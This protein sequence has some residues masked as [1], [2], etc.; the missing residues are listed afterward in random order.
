MTTTYNRSLSADFG[1]VLFLNVFDQE[2]R[3]SSITAVLERVDLLDDNVDIVFQSALS[4]PEIIILDNLIAVHPSGNIEV[5]TTE[6]M[7]VAGLG[8]SG[9]G[10]INGNINIDININELSELVTPNLNAD[11]IVVFDEDSSEHRKVLLANAFPAAVAAFD[12]YDNAGGQTFDGTAITVN[13]D[14]V[15]TN[16]GGF[17]LSSSEVTVTTAGTYLVIFRVSTDINTGGARSCSRAL[18]ELNTGGGFTEVDGS[19]GYMYNRTSGNA[20]YVSCDC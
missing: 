17:S 5:S 15:R 1:G 18:L 19:S 20:D 4:A 2:I 14:T 6:S 11:F 13:L 12:A 9:G 10:N 16:T 8:L 7:V 3:E